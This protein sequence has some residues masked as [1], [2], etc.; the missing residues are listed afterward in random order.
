VLTPALIPGPLE[1]LL[2]WLRDRALKGAA[3]NVVL[4]EGMRGRL[5]R[6]GVEADQLRVVPNWADTDAIHPLPSA[7]SATRR[8]HG[9]EGRFVVG[10]SGNFGR[11]HEFGTLLTAAGVLAGDGF[12]FLMTGGGARWRELRTAAE[13][14]GLSNMLFQGYQPAELLAD[15]L[16]AAD[17]H[18]VSLLPALEGLIV[19]SKVYGILAAG[20]PVL[21]IG[22]TQGDTAQLVREH[23]CGMAVAVGDSEGMVAWLRAL[24][25][26]P[27]R[28]ERMGCNARALALARYSGAG[29]AE[30]WMRM[31]H[32]IARDAGSRISA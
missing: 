28:L 18:L 12:T 30:E 13:A 16:A 25:A 17:V 11:A 26:A 31:L 8:R 22:D 7:R 10:Y 6:R 9:L 5:Q 29:A 27:E 21:F 14:A 32:G 24:R 19:P 23:D 15:S 3:V 20:R 2:T 4:S 1:R